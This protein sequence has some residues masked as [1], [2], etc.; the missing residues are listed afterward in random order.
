[1]EISSWMWGSSN[2]LADFWQNRGV[3]LCSSHWRL[4]MASL[5]EQFIQGTGMLMECVTGPYN[6]TGFK[7][8]QMPIPFYTVLFSLLP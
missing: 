4:S 7:S 8:S 2:K 6:T 1:M 3:K 5:M